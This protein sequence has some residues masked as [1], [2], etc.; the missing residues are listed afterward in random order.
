MS[1]K[2]GANAPCPC[3]SGKKYKRCCALEEPKTAKRRRRRIAQYT[4]IAVAIA[5]VLFVVSYNSAARIPPQRAVTTP[6]IPAQTPRASR[7]PG[8]APPGKVWNAD[9]GHWHDAP[10]GGVAGRTYPQ[11]VGVAA[12][13]GAVWS[14]EHDHWHDAAGIKVSIP[15]PAGLPPAGK[16]IWSDNHG[17]WH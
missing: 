6:L 14:P 7:P 15:Q 3:G 9:H 10:T 11:P 1:Q 12:P 5:A 4:A 8:P 2:V 16:T 17:H 13:P